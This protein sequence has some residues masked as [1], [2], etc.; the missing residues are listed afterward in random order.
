MLANIGSPSAPAERWEVE[1]VELPAS[2]EYETQP[3]KQGRPSLSKVGG[4]SRYRPAVLRLLRVCCAVC[5]TRL[6]TA[7]TVVVVIII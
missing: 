6:Q 5:S 2:L 4:A 3:Q 7:T 1:T